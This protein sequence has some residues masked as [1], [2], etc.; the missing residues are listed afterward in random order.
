MSMNFETIR[1]KLLEFRSQRDWE[2][3][4][5]P[6]NLAEGLMIEAAELLENFLWKSVEQSRMLSEIEQQR[7]EEEIGDIFAFLVYLCH[8]LKID[9][10]EAT[11]R[12]IDLNQIKYPVEKSRGKSAKYKDL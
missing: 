8:E 10:F 11:S 1:Q 12:K 2:P 6:K 9:L 7:V 4:H 3:F 5:D